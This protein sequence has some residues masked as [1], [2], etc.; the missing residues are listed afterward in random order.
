[1]ETIK[2]TQRTYTDEQYEKVET[3]VNTHNEEV[4][5]SLKDKK[6][7]WQDRYLLVDLTGAKH[8]FFTLYRYVKPI[9][10]WVDPY[11][12]M[13][14]LSIDLEVAV[15]EVLK[16]AKKSN[17]CIYLCAD[18]N[19]NP[20][21]T[22]FRKRT[23]EGIPNIPFGK[24]KG[25]SISDVWSI[26]QK[27]VMWFYAEYKTKPYNGR[28]PKLT[29]EDR[30]MRETAKALIEVFFVEYVKEKT[31]ENLKTSTSEYIGALKERF[32]HDLTMVKIKTRTDEYGNSYTLNTAKDVNGN[33]VEFYGKYDTMEE[34]KSYRI[35]GTIVDHKDKLGVKTTRIN[36]VVIESENN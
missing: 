3:L 24:Y 1:M 19:Y 36:R 8:V 14:N 7:Q 13:K 25:M 29:E 9:S 11:T 30:L 20:I 21:V 32:V 31:E 2:R 23:K 4:K 22:N 34:S 18:D 5:E 10:A 35:K 27:Y 15:E 28:E 33:Q 16:V 26:D 6:E 17:I 12:Y